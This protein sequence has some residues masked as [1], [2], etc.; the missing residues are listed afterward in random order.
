M[1]A[2]LDNEHIQRKTVQKGAAFM[3]L[4][5]AD[6]DTKNRQSGSMEVVQPGFALAEKRALVE[7]CDNEALRRLAANFEQR[8]G[9]DDEE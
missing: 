5:G 9:A 3:P 4:L 6:K 2:T 8:P 1:A 7:H